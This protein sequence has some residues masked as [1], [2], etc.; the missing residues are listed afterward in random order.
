MRFSIFIAKSFSESHSENSSILWAVK[1]V[2]NEAYS[3]IL[4]LQA[5]Q[6][7]LTDYIGTDEHAWNDERWF[8]H[9]DATLGHVKQWEQQYLQTL[10]K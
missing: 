7:L 2:S 4:I 8:I 6:N 3:L 5:F 10:N 9:P 1:S